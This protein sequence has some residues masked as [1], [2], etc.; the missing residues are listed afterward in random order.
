M[1]LSSYLITSNS[2]TRMHTM[3]TWIVFAVRNALAQKAE[4]VSFVSKVLLANADAICA[5]VVPTF[6]DQSI[7]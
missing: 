2:Y 3:L 1:P 4:K 7:Q 5:P 6:D